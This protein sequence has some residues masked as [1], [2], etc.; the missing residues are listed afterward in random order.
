W[1][2][3]IFLKFNQNLFMPWAIGVLTCIAF[4][5]TVLCIVGLFDLKNPVTIWLLSAVV[6]THPT[7]IAYHGFLSSAFAYGMAMAL[8]AFCVFIAVKCKN[9]TI[10]F[11]L[12]V[13]ILAL[14]IGTY[15][16]YLCFAAVLMLLYLIYIALEQDTT[17]KQI[18]L[19]AVRLL[20]L[21]IAGIVVYYAIAMVVLKYNNANWQSYRG[22]GTY[23][24]NTMHLFLGQIKDT[25]MFSMRSW[26]KVNEMGGYATEN[27]VALH[28]L[29]FGSAFVLMTAIVI[30]KKVYQKPL[31]LIMIISLLLM[32]PFAANS[33]YMLEPSEIP[34][35]LM[36]F[37]MIAPFIFAVIL[38]EFDSTELKNAKKAIMYII[39]ASKCAIII[40]T[41]ILSY[42]LWL[43]ANAAYLNITNVYQKS[44]V[45]ANIV[46]N[47]IKSTQGYYEN[48]PIQF[49]GNFDESTFSGDAP[50]R[51]K[52]SGLMVSNKSS[53]FSYA[54]VF[55]RFVENILNE[56][57]NITLFT[58]DDT[59]QNSMPGYPT[60]GY[61]NV[62]EDKMLVKL[63]DGK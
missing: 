36:R 5:I 59:L 1:A 4:S 6:V 28:K 37:G 30:V 50:E 54:G 39:G 41:C 58:K 44:F 10:S 24:L 61:I 45:V 16:S 8:S 17:F 60:K 7:V 47:D 32:I 15:Q 48:M 43:T 35:L 18:F 19:I 57:L 14:S 3:P 12:G 13:L 49:V 38:L 2:V 21:L 46:V 55:E 56:K 11:I 23:Q 22:I 25:W 42:N 53:A 26:F 40:L 51:E 9:K 29:L 34:H 27:V 33:I 52:L 62:L 20:L 31:K 63:G